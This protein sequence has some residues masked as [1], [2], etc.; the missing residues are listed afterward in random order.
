MKKTLALLLTLA[1]VFSM[2]LPA[3][4]FGF[5][6]VETVAEELPA[7]VQSE[8]EAAA[9]AAEVIPGKNLLTGK[10][11]V[12]TFDD[13][14]E[15]DLL[16][17]VDNFASKTIVE[18]P[19]SLVDESALDA[20]GTYGKILQ[21]HREP[22]DR[23][24]SNLK[25]NHTFDGT[26]KFWFT[27][28]H[29][30]DMADVKTN[31]GAAIW[32]I[33]ESEGN[34]MSFDTTPNKWTHTSKTGTPLNGKLFDWQFRMGTVVEENGACAN[35]LNFY[36]DNFGV[37][38]FYKI[39]YVMPDGTAVT[40]DFLF[41][42]GVEWK[43]ENIATE[44][45]PKTDNFPASFTKNG[46]IYNCIG[47][48]TEVN[49]DIPLASVALENA[50]VTLYPVLQE[51]QILN[52]DK[53][54]IV[55]NGGVANIT[56]NEEV[57]WEHTAVGA[58][59]ANVTTTQ[60]SATV[61]AGKENGA[62]KLTATLKSDPTVKAEIEILVVGSSN[63]RPGMNLFTGTEKA[64]DFE[65]FAENDET[66]Y[67]I[68]S[69]QD[70][71]K[72]YD[73]ATT[74][75]GVNYSDK[76]M[77]HGAT[78]GYPAIWTKDFAP[79]ISTDRPLLIEYDYRGKFGNHWMMINGSDAH[80]IFKN[81]K[82]D[83][84]YP[85]T[86]TWK[87]V[88]LENQKNEAYNKYHEIKKL[89]IEIGDG[90]DI[91][92]CVDNIRYVPYYQI[93][94]KNF[95]DSVAKTEYVLLDDSGNFMTTYTP[96]ISVV[97]GAVAYS[98]EKN[99]DA[100][101]TVELKNKD[102]TLYPLKSLS[103][104]ITYT[105]GTSSKQDKPDYTMDY[106]VLS[107]ESLGFTI[108]H[109]VAWKTKDG[110]AFYPNTVVKAADI[111]SI[112]GQTLTAFCQDLTKPAMGYAYEGNTKLGLAKYKYQEVIEDEGRTV[113]HLRLF[114]GTYD[115]KNKKWQN[116][117]RFHLSYSAGFDATEYNIVQYN[118]K[119][120]SS[121]NVTDVSVPAEPTP[122]QLTG[123]ISNPGVTIYCLYD[124]NTFYGGAGTMMI[125]NEDACKLINDKQY[126]VVE[127]DMSTPTH[128]SNNIQWTGGKN[129]KL[130][131]FAVDMNRAYYSG[132]TYLDYFRVYRDGV[133]T[134]TYDTNA[135]AGF[136][137]MI[138]TEVD[139]D[140]GRGGGTGYMLK[141]E[142]PVI[143]GF[144][145]RGWATKP[146]ATVEDVVDSIDLTGNT[147]VFAVW[148]DI[149]SSPKTDKSNVNIRSGADNVN[150]IRFASSVTTRNK[151]LLEEY[152]FIIAREDILGSNELTFLLKKE[153]ENKPLYVYGAAYDK[154][155][156]LDLQ[157]DVNGSNIIFTAVC[158]NI[159]AEHYATK[160]VARTYAK[161]A[162][163]GHAFTVYGDSVVKSI[164][165]VA[166]SIKDAGGA[167]YE[168]N[169][170][171]IDSILA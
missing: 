3:G 51:T 108:E 18:N 37:F 39:N 94:Y 74:K 9:L 86:D 78:G 76:A 110:R 50:D 143:T 40:E 128:Q 163:N 20:D 147:T 91:Y 55:A 137:D 70:N 151:A 10:S 167:A 138:Q 125:G 103:G 21:F 162:V 47:W 73:N 83:N 150:G 85:A 155:T 136:E 24:W 152:G 16:I 36:I 154:K 120:T 23:H 107:P 12:M 13:A 116:D 148:S 62:V 121:I 96:D 25:F 77:T 135:P 80:D 127:L 132:D 71:L 79:T 45:A 30:F 58:D 113:N 100:V 49:S 158:T 171:Y 140:T 102:I 134:V 41:A 52:A 93:T 4:A 88:R 159:P 112:K 144:T 153:D 26:R 56:A 31:W 129:G 59:G 82:G 156:G 165:E 99:G 139:P 105:D 115:D 145:F 87:H 160:L 15:A 111:D 168:D 124:V 170:E 27:W 64:L 130:Y 119:I 67:A 81:V 11:G 161:Y 66:L 43:A 72:I 104:P 109:F 92:I 126:H 101:E 28:D 169:K 142:H 89:A 95:D 7:A 114:G 123:E 146:D 46:K 48:S 133:F 14:T 98:L 166:Q 157:Y 32:F 75:N 117:A 54:V 149:P 8:P 5:E 29:Y 22:V 97:A 17:G 68:F 57:T 60:T 90:S 42:D 38:P 141:G 106:T 6:T 33:P 65:T 84:V 118:Y 35:P 131:G 122:E 61:T 1:M 44:Y 19:I 69:K 53:Y 2:V 34:H 63:W 164:K